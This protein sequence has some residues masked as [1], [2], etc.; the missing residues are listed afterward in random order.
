[1]IIAL[2]LQ[3]NFIEASDLK[4]ASAL[5]LVIVLALPTIKNK[6]KIA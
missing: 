3:L 1:V 6:L 5:I 4:L 2:I